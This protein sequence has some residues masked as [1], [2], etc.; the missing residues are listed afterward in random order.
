MSTLER[1]KKAAAKCDPGEYWL[2]T[3]ELDALKEYFEVDMFDTF[4]VAFQY[5]FLKG[6]RAE[7]AKQK[8]MGK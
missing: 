4:S 5:G 7:K 1:M 8:G 6:Q 3:E 2:N